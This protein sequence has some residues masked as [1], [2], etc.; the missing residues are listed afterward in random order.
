M[1]LDQKIEIKATSNNISWFRSKGYICD[2]IGDI[3][4][5]NVKDLKAGTA[6]K[7]RCKCDFCGKEFE[8][9]YNSV[10]NK[11]K[12]SC[13]DQ[14]CKQLLREETNMKL[15]GVTNTAYSKE[16]MKKSGDKFKQNYGVGSKGHDDYVKRRKETNVKNCGNERGYVDK[17]DTQSRRVKTM[18]RNFDEATC[19]KGTRKAVSKEQV[20]ICEYLDGI[21]NGCVIC[22]EK[23]YYGD[24]VLDSDFIIIEYNGE[25]HRLFRKEGSNT[26]NLN[27]ID[28]ERDKILVSSNWKIIRLQSDRDHMPDK[29]KTDLILARCKEIFNSTDEK[30]IVV[31]TIN[32]LIATTKTL[33]NL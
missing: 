32:D 16:L 23:R 9:A 20:Q 33:E 4:V 18:F 12:H 31:D 19:R 24:I 5:I 2:H 1:I 30:I 7:V 27:E 6:K 8:R 17:E 21:L 14:K 29:D 22:D 15:F 28:L 3:I 25:G 10:V 13:G 11:E 26:L